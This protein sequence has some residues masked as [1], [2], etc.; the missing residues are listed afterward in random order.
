MSATRQRGCHR[1]RLC[2]HAVNPFPEFVDFQI[3]IFHGSRSVVSQT[4]RPNHCW[5]SACRAATVLVLT[6]VKK[7]RTALAIMESCLTRKQDHT[8]YQA[9]PNL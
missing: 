1:I 4:M 6:Y 7:D 2:L 3:D 9:R 8:S 5:A